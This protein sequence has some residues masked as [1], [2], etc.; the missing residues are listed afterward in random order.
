MAILK[1]KKFII[2]HTVAQSKCST[3]FPTIKLVSTIKTLKL[4]LYDLFTIIL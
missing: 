4:A 1:L 3:L 2:Y